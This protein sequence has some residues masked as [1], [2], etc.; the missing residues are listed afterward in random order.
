MNTSGTYIPPSTPQI[1]LTMLAVP[2]ADIVLKVKNTVIIEIEE[3]INAPIKRAM[4]NN[5][6]DAKL[7][8]SINLILGGN[9]N[10]TIVNGTQRISV[11]ESL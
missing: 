2:F 10:A 11:A 1:V 7:A 3:V 6:K 9:K 4:A 5:I 8:G